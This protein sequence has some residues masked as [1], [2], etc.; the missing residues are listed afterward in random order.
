MESKDQ[1]EGEV[2]P[3]PGVFQ[4]AVECLQALYQ[5][6]VFQYQL[7]QLAVSSKAKAT[8]ES[9]SSKVHAIIDTSRHY[10]LRGVVFCLAFLAVCAIL[11]TDLSGCFVMSV[12]AAA[13]L[14]RYVLA[15]VPGTTVIPLSFNAMPFH[16]DDWQR[17]FPEDNALKEFFLPDK[18]TRALIATAGE[19]HADP[20]HFL[21]QRMGQLVDTK[22]SLLSHFV[23]SHLASTTMYIPRAAASTEV[24][25][26]R[27]GVNLESLFQLGP[28]MFNAR[29]EY[30]ARMQVVLAKEDVGRD[31]SLILESSMLFSED[32]GSVEPLHQ[33][34]VLFKRS[35]SVSTRTGPP[36]SALAVVMLKKLLRLCFYPPMRAYEYLVSSLHQRDNAAFPPIDPSRE[37]AVVLEVYSRFTPPLALQPRLRAINFSLYQLP[38]PSSPSR[39]KLSRL[40]FLSTVQLTGVARWFA[41]YPVSTFLVLVGVFLSVSAALSVGVLLG[42]AGYVYWNWFRATPKSTSS[43]D[44]DSSD[45]EFFVVRQRMPPTVAKNLSSPSFLR[46]RSNEEFFDALDTSQLRR[47]N[48]FSITPSK[49]VTKR[50]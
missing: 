12:A 44:K 43:S 23:N 2:P 21:E 16:S 35:T 47:A 26:P 1:P 45:S 14:R 15:N 22:F 32:A 5:E 34:D 41:D 18:E 40:V 10:V 28:A 39:V 9:G 49:Q 46:D 24:F 25:S 50:Q 6:G 4:A 8:Y 17:H 38:E 33:F 42:I 19:A 3:I 13:G 48:S 31:V 37:V 27:G 30:S 36:Y 20:T 11:V 29:G 7:V